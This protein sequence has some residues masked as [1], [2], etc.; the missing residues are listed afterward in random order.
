MS[1]SM[2]LCNNA[3]WL[4]SNADKYIWDIVSVC[5]HPNIFHIFSQRWQNKALVKIQIFHSRKNAPVW[6]E[7]SKRATYTLI[8]YNIIEFHYLFDIMWDLNLCPSVKRW[9]ITISGGSRRTV[10]ILMK[11]FF[12]NFEIFIYLFSINR[13]EIKHWGTLFIIFFEMILFWW[14]ICLFISL[15]GGFIYTTIC[16][17]DHQLAR[18]FYIWYINLL[19]HLFSLHQPNIYYEM[20]DF[21]C[22]IIPRFNHSDYLCS[23]RPPSAAMDFWNPY[24]LWYRHSGHGGFFADKLYTQ[25]KKHSSIHSIRNGGDSA[26]L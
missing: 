14:N 1:K 13:E 19:R 10:F 21:D 2:K 4:K 9:S 24:R 5:H 23:F 17:I 12:F 18:S 22:S 8:S 20:E 26:V 15:T 25:S 3:R 16:K 6:I 11:W 7:R